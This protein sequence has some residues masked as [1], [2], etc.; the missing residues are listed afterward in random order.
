MDPGGTRPRLNR[1][2]VTDCAFNDLRKVSR[3]TAWRSF[4]LHEKMSTAA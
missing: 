1:W 3:T 2:A 4:R